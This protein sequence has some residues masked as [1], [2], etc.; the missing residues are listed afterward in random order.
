MK[1]HVWAAAALMAGMA[2]SGMAAGAHAPLQLFGTPLAGA[3]RP[4]LRQVLKAHGMVA[5]REDDRYWADTYDPGSTLEGAD[6]FNVGYVEATGRF[7]NATYRFPAFMDT[8]LVARVVTM[9]QAKYG[10]PSSRTGRV[11][12]GPVRARWDFPDGMRI[13][14]SRDWPDTTT[15]LRF[16]DREATRV[17]NAEMAA[18][19]QRAARQQAVRQDSAY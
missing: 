10:P 6:A 4:S 18:E 1:W 3:T 2:G 7:A 17:E 5:T 19:E 9:V 13:E 11:E 16:E 12:L 8:G 15:Y 14:V